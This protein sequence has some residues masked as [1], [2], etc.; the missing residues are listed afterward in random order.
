MAIHI[1]RGKIL[2]KYVLYNTYEF[3]IFMKDEEL[4][5]PSEDLRDRKKAVRFLRTVKH[6]NKPLPVKTSK[7]DI[8][9]Y[10]I[11][12]W[13]NPNSGENYYIGDLNGNEFEMNDAKKALKD[14]KWSE[15]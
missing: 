2:N 4:N 14:L 7:G 11:K 1:T 12:R 10:R 3:G 5:F 8:L 6:N 15:E 13:G 9:I